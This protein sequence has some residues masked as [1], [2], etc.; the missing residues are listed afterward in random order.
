MCIDK[1]IVPKSMMS[2]LGYE[3][4]E[5]FGNIQQ[6]LDMIKI[7]IVIIYIRS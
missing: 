1:N 5:Q 4:N 2:Y 6:E 3:L 7:Y